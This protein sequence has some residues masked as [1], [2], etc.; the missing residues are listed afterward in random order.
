MIPQY[1]FRT[2]IQHGYLVVANKSLEAV[3]HWFCANRLSL[4]AKKNQ[5]MVI[6]SAPKK[7]NNSL[8]LK[9]DGVI[10]SQATHCKFHASGKKQQS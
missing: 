3:F 10:L 1:F 8:E 2:L 9:I 4:N 7:L 5:Y 6:Q